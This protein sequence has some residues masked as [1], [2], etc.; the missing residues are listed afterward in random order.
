[1]PDPG[2]AIRIRVGR[3]V[4][5]YRLARGFSQERLAELTGSSGKHVGAIERGQANVGLDVLGRLAAA[6]SVDV[7]ELF[8]QPRVRP[9]GAAPMHFIA[10]DDLERLEEIVRRVKGVRPRRASRAID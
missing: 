9:R 8:D 1:M 3:A 7:A 10:G 6:L 2:R 4:R 5:R